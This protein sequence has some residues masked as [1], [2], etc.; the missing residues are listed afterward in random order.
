MTDDRQP[1]NPFV[2][3]DHPYPRQGLT[4]APD[5][6]PDW[7]RVPVQP[8]P[9]GPADAWAVGWNGLVYAYFAARR[10]L[11]AD[12]PD[13]IPLHAPDA[14]G[15]YTQTELFA[16][17]ADAAELCISGFPSALTQTLASAVATFAYADAVYDRALRERV[18]LPWPAVYSPVGNPDPDFN[19]FRP[20]DADAPARDISNRPSWDPF[21]GPPIDERNELD[22]W[23]TASN[24]ASAKW[25]ELL[26]QG[27]PDAAYELYRFAKLRQLVVREAMVALAAVLPTDKR[28]RTAQTATDAAFYRVVD[29]MG[30]DE[31]P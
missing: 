10:A 24:W 14:A 26:P 11:A 31:P 9:A 15:K 13:G 30:D 18:Y 28:L 25:R 16:R 6:L 27:L 2:A 21:K 22:A 3:S 17:A 8:D 20:T 5:T 12:G 7:A 29:E 1:D 23:T 19:P 4:P